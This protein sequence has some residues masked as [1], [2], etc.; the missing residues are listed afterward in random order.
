MVGNPTIDENRKPR[1]FNAGWAYTLVIIASLML[2][3]LPFLGPLFF[4]V[5]PILFLLTVPA[6]VYFLVVINRDRKK[7]DTNS[8]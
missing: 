1:Q 4:V 2:I 7:Q 5:I 8:G 3:G 6:L